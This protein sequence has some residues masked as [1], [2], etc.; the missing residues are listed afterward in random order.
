MTGRMPL[1]DATPEEVEAFQR[2][3]C[4]VLPGVLSPAWFTALDRACARLLA[5]PEAV[6]ITEETL[7][8]QL[9]AKPSG[10]FGAPTYGALLAGRGRFLMVFNS[11][12]RDPAVHEFALSG[13][14]GA[15][16]ASLMRSVSARF[17]DDILFVKESHTE[18]ATEWHDD[19]GGSVVTGWQRCSVWVSL[20]D[21]TEDAGPVRFLRGSH[22]RFSGWRARGMDATALA[23]AH[24]GDVVSCPVR[25]GDVVVHHLDTIHAAGPNRSA[26]PRRAWALRY[27]GDDARF[28]LRPTRREPRERYNLAD[29]D[30]LSGPCFPLVWPPVDRPEPGAPRHPE[31]AS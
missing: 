5:A 31:P 23:A 4:V 13:A 10:L 14:V 8:L 29:G 12:R 9:P 27:A 18:E 25:A 28:L 15:I 16:A 24:A 20:A 1:R 26:L 3:G 19:D 7:R 6:D 11:A 17:V 2:D 30:P 22:R 21:V